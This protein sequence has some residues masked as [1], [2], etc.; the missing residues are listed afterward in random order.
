MLWHRCEEPT[1]EGKE[2][3]KKKEENA[4]KVDCGRNEAPNATF[5]TCS[6]N[7]N[8][9]RLLIEISHKRNA[10]VFQLE[11]QAVSTRFEVHILALI[12]LFILA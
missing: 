11:T 9:M 1:E 6:T 4:F 5:F 2:N 7:L 10:S 12:H 8:G 3:I